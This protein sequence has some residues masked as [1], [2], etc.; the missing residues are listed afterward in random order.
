MNQVDAEGR[1]VAI[2]NVAEAF[3]VDYYVLFSFTR[4]KIRADVVEFGLAP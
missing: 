2:V 1:A 3:E 4:V